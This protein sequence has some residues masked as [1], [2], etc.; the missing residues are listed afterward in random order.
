VNSWHRALKPQPRASGGVAQRFASSVIAVPAAVE[1][2]LAD[3][4]GLRL[5]AEHR[6]DRLR[7][8]ALLTFSIFRVARRRLDQGVAGVVVDELRVDVLDGA[9]DGE[10]WTSRAPADLLP[11]ARVAPGPAFAPCLLCHY[12]FAAPTLPAL[13]AL[14]RMYSPAYF[15]PFA[16]YGSGTRSARIFAATSPTT[17]LSTP[18]TLSFCGVSTVNVMPAGGSISIGCENPSASW[19]F[20]P[21]S[22]A[23]YP[24][25]LISRSFVKPVVTPAT[26]FAMSVRVSPCS[27]RFCLLSSARVTVIFPS[28][29]AIEMFSWNV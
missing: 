10:A 2:R 15:T 24:V 16:L 25:P 11:H 17:S 27:A 21:C 12:A 14:R 1:D 7:P 5:L 26:M 4:L 3:A 29:R 18:E 8:L 9:E 13:P 22:T 20:L 28:S 6:A 19:S 23:R